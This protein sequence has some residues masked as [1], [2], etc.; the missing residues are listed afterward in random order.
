M[1]YSYQENLDKL[2]NHKKKEPQVNGKPKQQA[3][4]F[5]SKSESY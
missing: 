2:P 3:N 4:K 5:L 1:V